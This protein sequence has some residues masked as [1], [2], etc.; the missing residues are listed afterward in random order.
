MNFSIKYRYCNILLKNI[1]F[2]YN[3]LFCCNRT[4]YCVNM[5][6]VTSSS[7][8]TC[9]TSAS[10]YYPRYQSRSS[11]YIRSLIPRTNR[12]SSDWSSHLPLNFVS[13]PHLLCLWKVSLNFGK[14]FIAFDVI[15][16][17]QQYVLFQML[18]NVYTIHV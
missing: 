13:A 1:N 15:G 16:R 12:G 14:I 8:Y 2:I 4:C 6:S 11:M 7:R 5:V 18:M 3:R 17:A 9:V 10:R